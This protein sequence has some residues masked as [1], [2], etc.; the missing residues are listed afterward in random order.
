MTQYAHAKALTLLTEEGGV[1]PTTAAYIMK[2]LY[3]LGFTV[4]TR[5]TGPGA[6]PPACR[7]S[8][9]DARAQIRAEV[10]EARAKAEADRQAGIAAERAAREAEDDARQRQ[11]AVARVLATL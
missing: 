3:D 9:A 11:L 2:R 8:G 10:A 4:R 7:V 5:D 1:D 6:S